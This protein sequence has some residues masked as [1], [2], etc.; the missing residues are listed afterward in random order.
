MIKALILLVLSCLRMGQPN[1]V[2]QR[3]LLQPVDNKSGISAIAQWPLILK[4]CVGK[5]TNREVYV[6]NINAS[7]DNHILS[8]FISRE[9]SEEVS[10]NQPVLIVN[11]NTSLFLFPTIKDFPVT[12]HLSKNVQIFPSLQNLQHSIALE[13]KEL[14][15][16]AKQ[17]YGEVSFFAELKDEPK[18]L[19]KMKKCKTGPESCVPQENFSF[20]EMLQAENEDIASCSYKPSGPDSKAERNVYIVEVT[21]AGPVS[22]H[23]TIDIYANFLNGPCAKPPMLFLVSDPDYEWNIQSKVDFSIQSSGKYKLGTFEVPAKPYVT[24]DEMV[25]KAENIN[26]YTITLIRVAEA[27]SVKIS[28]SCENQPTIT[29]SE[30]PEDQCFRMQSVCTDEYL[31]IT[32]EK[33]SQSN[34]HL[35][36]PENVFFEDPKCTAKLGDNSLVLVASK[37][38]CMSQYMSGFFINSLNI[39]GKQDNIGPQIINCESPIIQIEL[40]H[41][42][43]LQM[44]TTTLDSD[45]TVQVLTS[46]NIPHHNVPNTMTLSGCSLMV[47]SNQILEEQGPAVIDGRLV[48]TM[49]T[50]L[51]VVE[52]PVHGELTCTFCM[53]NPNLKHLAIKGNLSGFP[54][55]PAQFKMQKSLHLTVRAPNHK[56]GLGM[57]S[58]LGITFGAFF[59]GALLT[60]ALWY[61][62]THTRSS[63]KMQPVPR[64]TGG[65]ESSSTNHSIDST[66]STPCS[67]SSRA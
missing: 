6:L 63:V 22:S 33:N 37:N 35:P 15:Q 31:V 13:G 8:L 53:A 61:I 32:L 42:R 19:L 16:W 48:W 36:E 43:D 65:S 64:L 1:P 62:Y 46:V 51:P 49:N 17:V 4:G 38:E 56:Q 3:C 11:S 66:Q 14:L 47:H 29:T 54:D 58:V 23:K 5:V 18:I 52:A 12:L 39:K 10:K 40:R 2:P 59:I 25:E 55:C 9:G 34:C 67:T 57:G 20:G 24:Y 60:A 50:R 45:Q 30:R 21:H 41:G 28:M 44:N 26:P 27:R 7:K